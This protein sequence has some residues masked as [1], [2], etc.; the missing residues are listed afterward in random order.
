MSSFDNTH[1]TALTGL[2]NKAVQDVIA[3][4]GAIGQ[5][6]PS[7]DTLEPGPFQVPEEM[8]ARLT[9]AIQIIE[10]ACAQLCY[11]IA[12]PG[13][14]M[15]N[16]SLEHEEPAC[17]L[18]VTEARIP[19]LL[20]NKPE[21]VPAS[22]LASR[23]GLDA[24]KL[25]R[26]LRLL[27]TKHCFT[28]VKPGVFANNRLSMKLLSSDLVSSMV[29]M[30]ADESLKASA[31]F[32]DT[33]TDPSE[34]DG[35]IPFRR[36][37]GYS[38]F[39]Y[40][41]TPQGLKKGERFAK[42]MIGWGDVTGKSL[43]AKA[44]PWT[45]QPADITICDVGGGHGNIIMGLMKAHPHIK[46]V[47]Q[48]QP[49]VIEMAHKFWAEEHP[50]AIEKERIKFVPFDF[51]KDAP[52]EGC[53]FYYICG[54]L[55]DWPDAEC[56]LILK[57]VRKAMKP[58]SRVIIHDTVIRDVVR[59]TYDHLKASS[60]KSVQVD[61]APEPLLP[62]YGVGCIRTYG[63]DMALMHL[64]NAQARTLPEYIELGEKSGLRFEKLY[65]AGETDLV[66]FTPF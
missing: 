2:I 20:L 42:G 65:E 10:A 28:E 18:V 22:E 12:P 51:F 4:Y 1:I 7:L 21:G 6:I 48:D 35:G 49:Q 38:F 56:E 59:S 11:S 60:D 63:L 44:Y 3:E 5:A 31:Y 43:V 24:S 32:N 41:Q 39:D 16:K 8:P 36:A 30:F 57:N 13:H 55:H 33:L 53:D 47:L 50:E 58:S 17:L 14:V 27:A 26:V 62:N 15:I 61:V 19:D 46:T 45:S 52:I 40:Y 29:A 64:L 9:K 23:A 54:V 66:E 34:M 37:T 25:T